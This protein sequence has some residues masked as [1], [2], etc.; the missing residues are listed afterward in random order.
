VRAELEAKE[1]RKNRKSI[2]V[3]NSLQREMNMKKMLPTDETDLGE[4]KIGQVSSSS[5]QLSKVYEWEAVLL[6]ADLPNGSDDEK[7]E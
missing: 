3:R 1:K 5:Q 4:L 7:R 2:R 6:D